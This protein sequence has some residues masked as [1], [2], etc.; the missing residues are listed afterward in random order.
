VEAG[1]KMLGRKK[2]PL[3]VEAAAALGELCQQIEHY[4]ELTG[5]VIGQ[6]RRR[7]LEGEEVPTEEKLFSI[8]E[9]HT[10]LIKRGKAQKPDRTVALISI[11]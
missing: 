9:P 10:D 5:Q 6:S 2:A 11:I 4:V 3:P 7:A 8:F 1:R